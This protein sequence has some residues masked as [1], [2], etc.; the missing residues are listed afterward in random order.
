DKDHIEGVISLMES[1][2]AIG[3]I[4]LNSDALKSSNLWKHLVYL[5]EGFDCGAELT[6]QH[7]G[8]F[9]QGEISIRVLAPRPAL[10][11]IGPGGEDKK[12]RKLTSN[13][14]SAVIKL[15]QNEQSV[16][17]FPGDIDEVGLENLLEDN[18][19]L[20][21][22]LM[23]FPHHGGK[24]GIRDLAMFTRWLFDAVK[25]ETVIFSI[26]RGKYDTPQ[27][28]IVSTLRES[29]AEVR[30]ACTQL[31][32]HCADELPSTLPNHLTVA[33]AR[34]KERRECCGGTFTVSLDDPV[35]TLLPSREGHASFIRAVA[36]RAL[37]MR[38]VR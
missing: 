9:D 1:G 12:G 10:A 13:S 8:I 23:V 25:P 6:T 4:R 20:T 21:A 34:G 35:P 37:C 36:P 33:Y 5:L 15:V 14:T 2:Q 27:P 11:L 38:R 28:T 30:V 31:S 16:V 24:S 29:S 17:L 3:R 22:P 32:K 19:D 26:G 7:S 18:Q